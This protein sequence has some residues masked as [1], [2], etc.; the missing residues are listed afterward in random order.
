MLTN[1]KRG[2]S[3]RVTKC[4]SFALLGAW[5]I[6]FGASAQNARG[7]YFFAPGAYIDASTLHREGKDGFFIRYQFVYMSQG[8]QPARG[9]LVDGDCLGKKR[10]E[11]VHGEVAGT[12][13]WRAVFTGTI[14][15]AELET[16]CKFAGAPTDAAFPPSA[17]EAAPSSPAV[18]APNQQ[19]KLK[20]KSSG[21]GFVVGQ[22]AVVTNF[23][24]I[25]GCDRIRV[26]TANGLSDARVIAKDESG[27]LAALRLTQLDALPLPI[28][29]VQD[30]F[31]A[32]ITVSWIP[33]DRRSWRRCSRHCRRSQFS[34]WNSG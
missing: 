9:G 13:E 8:S 34:E 21:T 33:T 6:S 17:A 7:S 20:P 2:R 18:V 32:A 26:P 29:P 3:I 24:V 4:L 14:Q 1:M 10:I 30:S 23:H 28:S 15:A 27:D 22:G 16:A 12:L 5:A 25:E 19:A 11:H 31:G